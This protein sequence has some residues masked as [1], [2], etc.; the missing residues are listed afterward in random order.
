MTDVLDYFNGEAVNWPSYKRKVLAQGRVAIPGQEQGVLGLLLSPVEYQVVNPDGPHP[1]VP[2]VHPGERPE[3]VFAGATS[4]QLA[5]FAGQIKEYEARLKNYCDQQTGV[6]NV[7]EWLLSH[8]DENSK[9]LFDNQPMGSMRY[10]LRELMERLEQEYGTLAP[11]DMSKLWQR[12]TVSYP[13]GTN[14][15]VFLNEVGN[16]Y[17][18]ME[19][20]G[21]PTGTAL[22]IRN[23]L[24]SLKSVNTYDDT[25]A[26]W[27]KSNLTVASQIANYPALIAALKH[28]YD[29]LQLSTTADRHAVN[30]VSKVSPPKEPLINEKQLSQMIASGIAAAM[31]AASGICELC[32]V[33]VT[34]KSKKGK[35]HKYC[36][37]CFL[38]VRE[39]R[40]ARSQAAKSN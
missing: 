38:K 36:P 5:V 19:I 22:K 29:N 11:S 35:L 30:E 12:A 27:E 17:V 28:T 24:A 33:K 3:F 10:S 1:F 23:L 2:L 32:K 26:F 37:K 25:I 7:R 16:A 9:K 39:D 15:R 13:P 4:A 34:E 8:L 20:N 14:L 18:E 21:E 6:K 31:S 40:L